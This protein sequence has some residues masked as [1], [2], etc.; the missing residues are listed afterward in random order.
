[1]TIIAAAQGHMW[2]AT[3]AREGLGWREAAA[4]PWA[5]VVVVEAEESSVEAEGEDSSSVV[6]FVAVDV[7][8]AA[9]ATASFEGAATGGISTSPAA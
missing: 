3:R 8:I 4:R 9:A 1:M 7:S 2:R 5:S 6:A